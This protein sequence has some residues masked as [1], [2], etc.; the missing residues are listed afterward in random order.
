MQAWG[1][2]RQALGSPSQALLLED[3]LSP[4]EEAL[5]SGGR[6]QPGRSG[7]FSGLRQRR[8][9]ADVSRGVGRRS[10]AAV[11]GGSRDRRHSLGGP[12]QG[13]QGGGGWAQ[14]SGADGGQGSAR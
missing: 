2:E 7:S 11:G 3:G 12:V 1:S 13:T 8:G 9:S 10:S 4:E 5:L 14:S 6:E